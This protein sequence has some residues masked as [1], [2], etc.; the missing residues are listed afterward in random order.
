MLRSA[1]RAAA[2]SLLLLAG[3]ASALFAAGSGQGSTTTAAGT[4]TAFPTTRPAPQPTPPTVS[5]STAST[6]GTVLVFDG[7]G[8]GHGLGLSQ[9]GADGYARHGWTYDRILAH[10]YPGT[11]LG[12][13][14]VARVRVLVFAGKRVTLAASPASGTA[15][16][17]T[18]ADAAG[19]RVPLDASAPLSLDAGLVVDGSP[20]PSPVRLTSNRPQLVNGQAFRG[21]LTVL[22]DGKSLEVV[23]SVPLE[24]YLKGVVA[25]EMSRSWPLAALEAQAVA[26]RSYALANLQQGL[27]YD[28]FADGRSQNYA[29]VA[30]ETP[31]TNA[32]VDAT[33]GRV[34]LWQGKPADALYS[35]TSGG[36][37]ASAADEIGQPIPYLVPVAD[38]YDTL[39]PYHDWGPILLTGPAAAKAL[40]LAGD[41]ASVS[42]TIAG[43]G[44]VSQLT[45]ASPGLQQVAVPGGRAHVALGLPSNWFDVTL[46]QLA[47]RAAVV[48]AGGSVSLTGVARASG[49]P[50]PAGA[51]SLESS[52]GDGTWTPAGPVPVDAGGAFAVTVLPQVTT[53]YRLAFGVVR[54]GLARITVT[55]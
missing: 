10:Y 25:A 33:R 9:W 50:L 55:G 52:T 45:A 17:W 2:V 38:P 34:L 7:H 23:D 29:G 37:T 5:P 51:V 46:L 42:L 43:D 20:V 14:P 26:A 47:P 36:R 21:Q 1:F 19:A 32:A 15:S 11:T 48:T 31:A 40:G 4:T 12:T 24:A 54:A 27:P 3:T 53:S 39:S 41:V 44:R 16:T 6:A 49:G 8:Y 30:A 28:L 13:A 22:S 35:S 18:L